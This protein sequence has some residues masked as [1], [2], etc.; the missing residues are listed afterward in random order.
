MVAQELI[1]GSSNALSA[2]QSF[3][4]NLLQVNAA[5]RESYA[6]LHGMQFAKPLLC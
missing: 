3:C 5:I 6:I 2:L 4:G 1:N